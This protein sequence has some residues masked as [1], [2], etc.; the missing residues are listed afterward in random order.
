MSAITPQT[1][2]KLLKCPI[3]SDNR[4][5]LTFAN[6]TAQYNYFNSLPKLEVDNF[7]YQRK[8]SVIR[9]PAHIDTIL[10]YNYVMYQNEAYTNKWFYAFI[11]NMEYVN[12]NMT[13][14]TIKTDVYQTWMFNIVWKRSFIEREHVNSDTIGEH[15]IGENVELGDY[16]IES[17]ATNSTDESCYMVVGTTFYA[18]DVICN[19]SK[20]TDSYRTYN[21]IPSG[22]YYYAVGTQTSYSFL[23]ALIVTAANAGKSDGIVSLF[24]APKKLLNVPN[25][26]SQWNMLYATGSGTGWST[27]PSAGLGY[28]PY[29][30]IPNSNASV[31]MET[32]SISKPNT[33]IDGYTPKNRKLF[34]YPF[35]YLVLSNNNGGASEYHYE[36][37][38]STP[39]FKIYGDL[40]PGCSIR[41]IPTNYKNQSENNLEG[42]NGGKYPIGSWL[43]DVYTNWLTQNGVNLG[44]TTLNATE[45]G[46]AKGA[47]QIVGGAGLMAAGDIAGSSMLGIGI[48]TVFNAIQ[49]DYQHSLIPPQ[50]SGNTNCGDVSYST[51]LTKF[52]AYKMSIKNEVARVIDNYFS[53]YGYKVNTVKTPNITGR[54]NWNYVKTIGANIEGDIPENDINELKTMFNNGITLWHK[55]NYYLD[56]SQSN[57]IA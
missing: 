35:K 53:M 31:L 8:D 36:Y 38:S 54:T 22:I 25:N 19:E 24:M 13:L 56:Y 12:D 43:T 42:I 28:C 47:A 26:E 23:S 21:G 4:N 39:A 44:F 37:F 57:N 50:V 55:T 27:N 1:E 40:T 2:L 18:P 52:T 30:P 15:T 45:A 10:T 16:I 5:Q 9:Y 33:T 3:E 17:S 49:Q 7:T 51:G 32:L 41:A 29:Y 11:T 20:G 14:I 48:N 6:E 46:I 34:T